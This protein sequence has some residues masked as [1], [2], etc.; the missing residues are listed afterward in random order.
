MEEIINAMKNKEVAGALLDMYAA[1]TKKNLLEG[2]D[3]QLNRML[4]YATGYGIVLS[5]NMKQA[6]PLFYDALATHKG[7]IS[8]IIEQNTETILQVS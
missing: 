2:G 4:Q 1:A 8:R 7:E 6:A 5:G 3:I